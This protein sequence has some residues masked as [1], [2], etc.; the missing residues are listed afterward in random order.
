[1]VLCALVLTVATFPT[2]AR[3][4]AVLVESSPKPGE[5]L[6]DAPKGVVLR[7]NAKIEKRLTR[8]TLADGDGKKVKLPPIREDKAAP[9]N[10]LIIPL[11]ELKPGVYRLEYRV[12][13]A[14]GHST[15]GLLRFEIARPAPA[16]PQAP[17]GAAK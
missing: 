15:P 1:M 11:P 4:H 2:A 3:A 14:D 5:V 17:E 12:L 8:V 10:E 6:K 9:A 7:F 16:A 13:A